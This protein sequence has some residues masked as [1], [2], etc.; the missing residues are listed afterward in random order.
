MTTISWI[1]PKKTWTWSRLN[2]RVVT[3]SKPHQRQILRVFTKTNIE[4][5]SP[6]INSSWSLH[7][8]SGT[9]S[10]LCHNSSIR[11]FRLPKFRDQN[12]Q[13]EATK[14]SSLLMPWMRPRARRWRQSIRCTWRRWQSSCL[15][16]SKSSAWWIQVRNLVL[17]FWADTLNIREKA[18]R[19]GLKV[20]IITETKA[21]F[22]HITAQS[23]RSTRG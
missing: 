7:L 17:A 1:S 19:E 6:K 5:N 20:I 4:I 16:I 9:M 13:V 2:N 3:F 10:R 12:S 23:K 14:S 22:P 8:T 21:S 11:Y 15:R 18:F